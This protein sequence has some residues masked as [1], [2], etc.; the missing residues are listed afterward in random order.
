MSTLSHR[1]RRVILW[2]L[3]AL[4]AGI[5]S[6]A[7][8]LPAGFYDTFP[9]GSASGGLAQ[10]VAMDGPFNEHLT[11]DVGALYLALAAGG[12]VAAVSRSEAAT[13]VIAVAWIVFSA[14][15]LLYH[16]E[17]LHGLAP[18]DAIAEPISLALTLL[19]PIPLLFSGRSTRR[20]NTDQKE[21]IR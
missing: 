18:L 3:S 20:V 4:A 12:V 17:H 6:W 8:F 15:H 21:E 19:L 9:D 2:F 13:R 16:L 10:W 5:G 1:A 7:L 14:P 11:R